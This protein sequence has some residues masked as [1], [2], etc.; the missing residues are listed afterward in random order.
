MNII[1]RVICRVAVA[2]AA[3]PMCVPAFA[4]EYP[5]RPIRLI[6]PFAAGGATDLL[7]RELGQK[8][9]ERW[10]KQV[11]V[12]NRAG[13]GGIIGL[14][15]GARATP[16]GYTLVMCSSS[17]L[18]LGP[19]LGTKLPYDP[20]KSFTHIT[21]A[22][23]IPVVLVAHPSFPARSL[24]ELIKVAKG[25]PGQYSYASNGAGTTT[26][27]AGELLKRVAGIDL[28]HV[29]Y[30]GGGA[31]ITDAIGGQI[32]LLLGAVS[33]PMPHIKSGKLRALG[34][35]SPKR[36]RALPEVPTFAESIPGFEVRQWFG[37]CAPAG[38]PKPIV[39][40]LSRELI[41]IVGE[42]GSN[43]RV[44]RA[45]LEPVSST[46]EKFAAY[47]KSELVKWTRLLKEMNIQPD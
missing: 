15:A 18:I 12:D 27:I 5:D 28:I 36:L 9:T 24:P 26:H 35:T 43:E 44:L 38:L 23:D 21:E 34:V 45:G 20:I 47:I 10:G 40:K 19:A 2:L 13:A 39:A 6:V 7:A 46:P 37:V 31:A 8:L 29:P 11:V 30:K 25:K 41:G 17:T 42:L 1:E 16:D 32:P 22:A 14:D 4:Q 33:T 3:L